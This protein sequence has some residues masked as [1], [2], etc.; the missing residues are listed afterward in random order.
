MFGN[1]AA[2]PQS[3]RM[4]W[5]TSLNTVRTKPG[6]I[7]TEAQAWAKTRQP[8]ARIHNLDRSD[9]RF[10]WGCDR[11]AEAQIGAAP[12][13]SAACSHHSWRS[14]TH[15]AL[16]RVG[17]SVPGDLGLVHVLDG[18]DRAQQFPLGR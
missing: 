7:R 1:N 13:Y 2:V 12:A 9:K 10:P 15:R 17:T 14:S 4:H 3:S 6:G 11:F 5:V 8:A 18:S 16:A